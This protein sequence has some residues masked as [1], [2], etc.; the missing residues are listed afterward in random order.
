MG[1]CGR[2]L[3]ASASRGKGWFYPTPT[4]A[5]VTLPVTWFHPAPARLPIMLLALTS[6]DRDVLAVLELTIP[7]KS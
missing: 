6:P 5:F 2:A 7:G 4:P 3:F 1:C